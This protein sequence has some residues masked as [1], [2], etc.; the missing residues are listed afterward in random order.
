MDAHLTPSLPQHHHHNNNSILQTKEDLGLLDH[1][2][3]L[4]QE[5]SPLDAFIGSAEDKALALE[6]IRESITLLKNERNRLP[7]DP[8]RKWNILVVGPTGNSLSYQCG[9]WSIHW[10]GPLGD[11][12]I[13]YGTTLVQ[14]L[15]QLAAHG[16]TVDYLEGV[17]A[18]GKWTTDRHRLADR[19]RQA[20]VIVLSVGEH[21]YA[22]AAANI[23]DV[24]LPRGQHDLATLLAAVS[25]AP[26]V[27]VLFE[28][29]PRL[30]GALCLFSSPIHSTNDQ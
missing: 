21:A 8:N 2:E 20:D 13:P 14:G 12:E 9:G 7:L 1:P 17:D 11:H 19:A 18:N 10:H 4:V 3:T 30:L 16:S 5:E 25:D 26:I 22:E 23:P 15:K 27:T 6:A 24:D 28:G 29:R